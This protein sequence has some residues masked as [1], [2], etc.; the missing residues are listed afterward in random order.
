MALVNLPQSTSNAGTPKFNTRWDIRSDGFVINS[1]VEDLIFSN[2]D[3]CRKAL[4]WD[5][6]AASVLLVIY[7]SR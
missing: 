7:N 6:D 4:D 5:V 2:V 3:S 1:N